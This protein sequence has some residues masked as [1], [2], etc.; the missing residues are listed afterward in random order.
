MIRVNGDAMEHEAGLT[1]AGLLKR[2]GFTFPLLVVRIDGRLVERA[3]Y[4][5]T[6]V[7]DGAD[8]QVLHLLAGG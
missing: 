6:S 4:A 1:V 7:D 8:V 5:V 2:R 3:A